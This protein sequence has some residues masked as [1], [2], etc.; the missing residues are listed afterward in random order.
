[1]AKGK[2][3]WKY[4]KL[5]TGR[6]NYFDGLTQPSLM[7]R[8]SSWYTPS[9]TTPTTQS[10][11]NNM[12]IVLGGYTSNPTVIK[13]GTSTV[14]NIIAQN[15]GVPTPQT[16]NTSQPGLFGQ[17]M[18]VL[19]SAI[20]NPGA[21]LGMAGIGPAALAQGISS[22]IG[23]I[24][25]IGGNLIS[26]GLESGAGSGISS[27]GNALSSIPILGG[28]AQGALNII[29]GGVNALIGSKINKEN[30]SKVQNSIGELNSFT[31]DA[32][33]F[34][35]L[36]QNWSSSPAGMSFSDS[37]IGKDGLLSNKAKKKAADL[38]NQMEVGKA[39]VQ[40]SLTNNAKNIGME[41][42]NSLESNFA[43]FG[44]ELNTQGG[45]F[46]IIYI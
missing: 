42:M 6:R 22:A 34:D 5:L 11:T 26:N 33:S 30:V 36:A 2:S 41:Q 10:P 8:S 18:G 17:A 14:S 13:P 45:D 29:G 16:N 7:Q 19:G 23:G 21:A 40:R 25:Q 39:F 43:A 15:G 4:N 28:L 35:Q 3:T 46:T 12:G 31:S 24:G 1:M 44:G 9:T 37:F 20:T 27:V 32:S 38:R